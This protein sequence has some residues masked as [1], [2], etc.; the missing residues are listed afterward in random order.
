MLL[1]VK[2]LAGQTHVGAWTPAAL[3]RAL[4][5][6]GLI[7][8]FCRKTYES[9]CISATRETE[10]DS[11]L[12]AHVH[13]GSLIHYLCFVSEKVGPVHGFGVTQQFVVLQ[14]HVPGTQLLQGPQ[15]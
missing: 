11:G 15:A 7:L 5:V 13:W 4:L 14:A 3:A 10:K 6:T 12:T 9:S 1:A 2:V 8:P